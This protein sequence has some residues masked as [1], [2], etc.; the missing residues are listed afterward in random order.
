ML[1]AL[2]VQVPRAA[3]DDHDAVICGHQVLGA[4]LA[5]YQEM[6]G[7]NSPLGC[8]KTDE[9]TTPNGVGRYNT[10]VGGSIY[11]S[12]DTGAHPVWGAIGDKWGPWAGRPARS[13]FPPGTS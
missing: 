2:A 12:P 10:F 11:W 4:I 7:E 8:P 13:A 9:L 3:A 1:L 5:K 6:G